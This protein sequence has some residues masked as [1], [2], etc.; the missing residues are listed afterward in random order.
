MITSEIFY[1][2]LLVHGV[3]VVAVFVVAW[4]VNGFGRRIIERVIRRIVKVGKEA[5]DCQEEKKREDTLIKIFNSSLGVVV[6]IMAFMAVLPEFGI[7]VT[8]FLAGAGIL[9]LVIG[10]GSK[11]L[12]ADFLAGLFIIL[13]N[14]YRLGDT[15]AAAG[16]EGTVRDM[17]FRRTVLKDKEGTIH[18][19]PNGQIKVTSNKSERKHN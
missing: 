5:E 3:K 16:I 7:S 10:M 14:Q 6:W 2:W 18:Y 15:I 11:D 13:E 1:N 4:L 17:N 9:G 19:I 8:P 12:V